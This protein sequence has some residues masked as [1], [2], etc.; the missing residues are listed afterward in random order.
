MPGIIGVDGIKMQEDGDLT[1]IS[2][3]ALTGP[4]HALDGLN[5]WSMTMSKRDPTRMLLWNCM[6]GKKKGMP[7]DLLICIEGESLML[8]GFSDL[9]YW[10]E[11]LY[12]GKPVAKVVDSRPPAKKHL[13]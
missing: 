2:F 12:N 10:V 9:R 1:T 4:W 11:P 5:T 7:N 6:E 13:Y 8:R 3:V